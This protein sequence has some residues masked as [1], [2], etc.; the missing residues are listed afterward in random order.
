VA[1]SRQGDSGEPSQRSSSVREQDHESTSSDRFCGATS[2]E[3]TSVDESPVSRPESFSAPAKRSPDEIAQA[4][5][6]ANSPVDPETV[7]LLEAEIECLQVELAERDRQL[8]ELSKPNDCAPEL[9]EGVEDASREIERLMERLEQLLEELARSDQRVAALE[10]LLRAEQEVTQ[11]QDEERQQ[12][13]TWIRE[14][15]TRIAAREDEWQAEKEVLAARLEQFKAERDEADRQFHSLQQDPGMAAERAPII[16]ELRG[17]NDQLR[18]ELSR[19]AKEKSALLKELES[20]RITDADDLVQKQVDEA[21]RS[22]RLAISQER[23]EMSRL[24]A[25]L[26]QKTSQIREPDE[27]PKASDADERYLALRDTLKELHQQDR[28][29]DSGQRK[30]GLATRL[31]DLWR[32]LDGPTDTD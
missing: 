17:Q 21:L 1:E 25:E 7:Q 15:E 5:A 22:E 19:A 16:A 18:D 14:I 9:E 4:W 6:L 10:E 13:E 26:A 11:A 24:R 8:D 31:A 20:L 12:M 28:S 23:A 29:S 2:S 30:V 27:A 3:S 32:R